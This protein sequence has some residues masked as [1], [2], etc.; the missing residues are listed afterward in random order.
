MYINIAS[1]AAW[2][3][4]HKQ[5]RDSVSPYYRRTPPDGGGV[6][7]PGRHVSAA[8]VPTSRALRPAAHCSALGPTTTEVLPGGFET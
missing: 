4:L 3:G 7:N 2:A 1:V 5:R 8:G 6:G